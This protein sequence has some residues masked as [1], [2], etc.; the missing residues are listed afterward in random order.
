MA[1]T[2]VANPS[3]VPSAVADYEAQ[4]AHISAFNTICNNQPFIL[5]NAESTGLPA[6]VKGSY[7]HFGD[8]LYIVDTDDYIIQ[9]TPVDGNNYIRINGTTTLTATWIQDISSYEW[10]PVYQYKYIGTDIYNVTHALLPY[11]VVKD[12]TEYEKYSIAL[13]ASFGKLK[14]TSLDT[15]Q[16]ANELYAMNQNVRTTDSPT[17]EKLTLTTSTY[18]SKIIAAGASWVVPVGIYQTAK[19]VS[20]SPIRIEVHNGSTWIG[21]A[22]IGA[23]ISDGANVRVWNAATTT[24]TFYY[25]KFS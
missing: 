20:A 9:G 5:T 11:L 19:S 25:R 1:I 18:D 12:G 6:I 2:Q 13:D 21:Y 4:N 22:D 16:G 23:V 15:G 3:S 14:S 24:N 7:I 10:N 8:N 17:F